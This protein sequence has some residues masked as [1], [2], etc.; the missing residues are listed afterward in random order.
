MLLPFI[1]THFKFSVTDRGITYK[2]PLKGEVVI[3]YDQ[4]VLADMQDRKMLLLWKTGQ[5][6]VFPVESEQILRACVSDIQA[7]IQ[8]AGSHAPAS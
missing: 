2:V 4:L 8:A 6:D 3:P 1:N 5:V 7:R